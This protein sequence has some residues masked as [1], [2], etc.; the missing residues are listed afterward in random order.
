MQDYVY[1]SDER[2]LVLTDRYKRQVVLSEIGEVGQKK[3]SEASILCVGA[4]GL[5]SPALL[6]LAAAG[7][8]KIGIIDQDVVDSSN[9]QRQVLYNESDIGKSK[10]IQAAQHLSHM[11]SEI[12]VQ[13]YKDVLNLDNVDALFS[14]YDLILDGTDNFEAKFLINDAAYKY[15]KPFVYGAIQGFDG[16]VSVFEGS[17]GPCYRCLY[18]TPPKARIA[19]CAESGVIGAV[20]GLV[21]MTQA[22]QA[23]QYI[24]G[25]KSFEPLVGKLWM[26]DSKTMQTR[27]LDIPKNTN[28]RIC[29]ADKENITLQYSSPICEFVPEVTVKQALE[30]DQA[31]FLDVREQDE[32]DEEHINKA[33]HWP[34]SKLV[35]NK[36]P[37]MDK[38][39]DIV[40]YCQKGM[41]SQQAAQI[42][43]SHGFLNVYNLSGGYDDWIIKAG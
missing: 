16:Q 11:N 30:M 5:G 10:A 37:D 34:L 28:C 21:G 22:L 14:E 40:L 29:G 43:K 9:L 13:T 3:L 42:M 20:A 19:N 31:V 39:Y 4:G 23:I 8:G 27:T 15:Q 1:K 7:I 36:M 26:I 35:N 6:Y 17:S 24:V 41:R 2:S 33:R 38:N 25:N 18:P 12:C 32:W